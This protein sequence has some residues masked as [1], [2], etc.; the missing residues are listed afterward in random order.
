MLANEDVNQ[1]TP[2]TSVQSVDYPMRPD[3]SFY[4]YGGF[5]EGARMILGGD[6]SA[7]KVI[8]KP[9]VSVREFIRGKRL[10][11]NDSRKTSLH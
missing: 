4:Q 3:S 1:P 5:C 9:G 10:Y 7:L 8:R 2:A 11:V 6:K